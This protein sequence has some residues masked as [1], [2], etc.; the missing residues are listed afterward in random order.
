M[1]ESCFGG[2]LQL[3]SM[4]TIIIGLCHTALVLAVRKL[5]GNKKGHAV[6]GSAQNFYFRNSSKNCFVFRQLSHR[7]ILPC[8]LISNRVNF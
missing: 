8:C 3:E 2:K 7:A 5:V 4:G 1:N 6:N